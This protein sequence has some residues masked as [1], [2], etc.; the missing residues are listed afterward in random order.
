MLYRETYFGGKKSFWFKV[1][2]YICRSQK[3]YIEVDSKDVHPVV[4]TFPVILILTDLLR[5]HPEH[6]CHTGP[7]RISD[8]MI[9]FSRNRYKRVW[10]CMV[11]ELKLISPTCF[12]RQCF[13]F[14]FHPRWSRLVGHVFVP[15]LST[16]V[17]EKNKNKRKNNDRD[18]GWLY[19]NSRICKLLVDSLFGH[20]G[21]DRLFVLWRRIGLLHFLLV[22]RVGDAAEMCD[23]CGVVMT[24]EEVRVIMAGSEDESKIGLQFTTRNFFSDQ[25]WNLT[26]ELEVKV[27]C[28]CAW[29][30]TRDGK[31]WG[32]RWGVRRW[33]GRGQP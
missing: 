1:N 12:S 19:G 31:G 23:W 32:R 21:D 7:D 8:A 27:D 22:G 18:Q 20:R 4:E 25:K 29:R 9:A 15:A 10:R 13:I 3:L 5:H 26:K 33:G 14:S 17:K 28:L 30:H 16:I 2:S 6:E 24:G 11:V